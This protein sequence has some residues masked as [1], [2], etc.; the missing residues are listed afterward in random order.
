MPINIIGF[1]WSGCCYIQQ[2][3]SRVGSYFRGLE[4]K[5]RTTRSCSQ[6]TR[7][8]PGLG[9]VRCSRRLAGGAGCSSELS[10]P[11]AG[12]GELEPPPPSIPAAQLAAC[13]QHQR[14]TTRGTDPV[15]HLVI[16]QNTADQQRALKRPTF[17]LPT[18]SSQLFQVHHR[19]DTFQLVLEA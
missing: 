12:Q 17:L 15:T 5:R 3:N 11:N 1:V 10:G 19:S 18:A 9:C 16:D 4:H 7:R 6:F 8:A 2:A 14:R 13:L